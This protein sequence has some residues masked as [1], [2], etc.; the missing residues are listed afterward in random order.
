[1]SVLSILS[2]SS[3]KISVALNNRENKASNPVSLVNPEIV[4]KALRYNTSSEAINVICDRL[5]V[6]VHFM[7]LHEVDNYSSLCNFGLGSDQ[8][9]VEAVKAVAKQKYLSEVDFILSQTR[10]IEYVAKCVSKQEK[11]TTVDDAKKKFA[12]LA[13]QDRR[14]CIK[15]LLKEE[16][17]Y[18]NFYF[19]LFL[20]KAWERNDYFYFHLLADPTKFKSQAVIQNVFSITDARLKESIQ[21]I[22]QGPKKAEN[23]EFIDHIVPNFVK[24]FLHHKDALNVEKLKEIVTIKEYLSAIVPKQ[25]KDDDQFIG[26]FKNL[27]EWGLDPVEACTSYAQNDLVEEFCS[28]ISEVP[29]NNDQLSEIKKEM[30][31]SKCEHKKKM[32]HAVKKK[33]AEV[34]KNTKHEKTE[35]AA[36]KKKAKKEKVVT[37]KNIKKEKKAKKK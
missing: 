5:P 15:D 28:V 26:K 16:V 36:V 3:S 10:F 12:S 6:E 29:L 27:V 18:E 37:K 23:F 20:R 31:E 21:L 19:I 7:I 33:T 4:D 34:D 13:P 32:L 17:T 2:G 1:M 24:F 9:M 22:A 35:A 8:R 25:V 30:R 11:P 14:E